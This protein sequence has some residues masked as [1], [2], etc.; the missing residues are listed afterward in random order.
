MLK[1]RAFVLTVGAL[2]AS[3]CV[4]GEEST[5]E[6]DETIENL[7]EAGF[8]EADIQVFGDQVY[9]GRD[10]EVS[11]EAS[12]E[13]IDPEGTPDGQEQY[14]TRNLVGRNLRT[15]CVRPRISST[16]PQAPLDNLSRGLNLAIQNYNQL[17]L[18]FTMRALPNN[19]SNTS[20][21]GHVIDAFVNSSTGGSAGF[22]SR[23]RP[24][25]RI[26][27]GIGVGNLGPDVSEH[28]ITHELGHA[29][30]FRHTDFFNRSISCGS[31]GS[32]GDAGVGAIHVPGTPTGATVGGSIM[33]SCFRRQETGEFAQGDRTALRLGYGR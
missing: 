32:E 2:L 26:T 21:C 24:F 9:V 22:P 16:W 27:I 19:S 31:G 13:M 30:G 6:I 17:N 3:A 29:V 4:V 8:P 20:G 25:S 28:V 11:L 5:D 15:I 7:I 12:R 14:R 23:G 33:N 10:A 1:N 18:T